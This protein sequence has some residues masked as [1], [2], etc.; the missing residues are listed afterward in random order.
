[1][2]LYMHKNLTKYIDRYC[3][4]I[5][6]VWSFICILIMLLIRYKLYET[7]QYIQ[8]NWQIL[9]NILLFIYETVIFICIYNKPR[10]YKYLLIGFFIGYLLVYSMYIEG[11]IS[12][13]DK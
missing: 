6:L 3:S 12:M 8:N 1:M 2:E 4:A 7:S 9:R 11:Q 10:R 5:I 13:L